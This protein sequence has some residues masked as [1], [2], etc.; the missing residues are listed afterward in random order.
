MLSRLTPSKPARVIGARPGHDGLL[1]AQGG[2]TGVRGRTHGL[3]FSANS[4]E[5]SWHK[6][7]S[8]L[9]LL[10]GTQQEVTHEL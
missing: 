6:H 1:P 5:D 3:I 2:R 4:G 7:G 8:D 10:R 9:P